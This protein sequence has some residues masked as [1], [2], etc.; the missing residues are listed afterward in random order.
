MIT[1]KIEGGIGNNLFQIAAAYSLALDNNTELRLDYSEFP[2]REIFCKDIP[3][4][5]E[6]WKPQLIWKE[7]F[8]EYQPI[9]F[10]DEMRLEGYFQNERYFKNHSDEIK[11]CFTNREAIARIHDWYSWENSASI[12]VRHGDFL[13]WNPI[14]T[15]PSADYY[16]QAIAF[17]DNVVEI[18]HIYVFSDDLPWCHEN[19]KDPRIVFMDFGIDYEDFF[20]MS[21][22][23][24]NII[25]NST[26]SWWA[27]YLN[28]N[29]N[30]IV[31]APDYWF[32]QPCANF[33]FNGMCFLKT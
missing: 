17:L 8:G 18:N 2:W 9:K 1:A 4:L 13:N 26:Y 27:S 6:E 7:V 3:A 12:H 11:Y 10:G 5:P 30:K 29:K 23:E 31:I 32:H 19:L 28:E 24:H 16:N 22:C 15:L 33:Y 14:G 20:M 21:L 25:A